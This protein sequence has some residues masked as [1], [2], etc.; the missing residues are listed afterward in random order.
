MPSTRSNSTSDGER[1]TNT[2]SKGGGAGG[3]GGKSKVNS[4]NCTK[5]SSQGRGLTKSLST[6]SVNRSKSIQI[7]QDL[8]HGGRKGNK[9]SESKVTP[10]KTGQ[11]PVEKGK[12]GRKPLSVA[13]KAKETVSSIQDDSNKEEGTVSDSYQ[14]VR[15]P[16]GSACDR[17][18]SLEPSSNLSTVSGNNHFHSTNLLNGNQEEISQKETSVDTEHINGN[19]TSSVSSR[20]NANS[21]CSSV[22]QKEEETAFF[23]VTYPEKRYTGVII[24]SADKLELLEESCN[25]AK[26]NDDNSI[27]GADHPQ[28]EVSN[29][30]DAVSKR[31]VN[32]LTA[33]GT[34]QTRPKVCH[35]DLN[36]VSSDNNSKKY[37]LGECDKNTLS[38]KSQKSNPAVMSEANVRKSGRRSV[39]NR[40]YLDMEMD[41]CRKKSKTASSP[42]KF[43][44]HLKFLNIMWKVLVALKSSI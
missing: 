4:W 18:T 36:A 13:A 15:T 7:E 9:V 43:I 6:N 10:S 17:K 22:L 27:L 35:S 33:Q 29:C 12:R 44:I 38:S 23:G 30:S 39:P 37:N 42:G 28:N 32:P 1:K 25:D 40:K 2:R 3:G 14:K 24:Q 16:N 8:K 41:F 34:L 5:P 11:G 20:N 21:V 26:T 31:N 19:V